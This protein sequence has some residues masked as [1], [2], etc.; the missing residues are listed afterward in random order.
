M[1]YTRLNNKLDIFLLLLLSP[2]IL[3]FNLLAVLL[4]L[5]NPKARKFD[6][7]EAARLIAA[8]LEGLNKLEYDE[9]RKTFIEQKSIWNYRV[10]GATGI[11][12]QVEI[13]GF[14]EDAVDL[15]IRIIG[16][17]D[18]GGLSAYMPLCDSLIVRPA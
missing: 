8:E 7:D 5:L 4:M 13:Q 18:N 1:L 10:T 6:K 11:E 17:I 2:A 3:L 9:L 16:S 14:W 15:D 12:Y